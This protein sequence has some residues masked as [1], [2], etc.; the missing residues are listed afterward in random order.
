M[1]Q[2]I[3]MEQKKSVNKPV[4]RGRGEVRKLRPKASTG[5]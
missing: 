2:R 1:I 4:R 3:T 5:M